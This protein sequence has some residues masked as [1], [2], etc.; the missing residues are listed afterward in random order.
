MRARA[1][2]V[3]LAGLAGCA[4]P[5]TRGTGPLSYRFPEAFTASQVVEVE[6]GGTRLQFLASVRRDGPDCRVTLFD[7][8]FSVPLVEARLEGGKASEELLAPGPRPGDG[9]RLVQLLAEV[10]GRA[11]PEREGEAEATT[12]IGAVHLAGLPPP[13][14]ACRLPAQ[15]QLLPRPGLVVRVRT[16]EGGGGGGGTALMGATWPPG[17]VAFGGERRPCVATVRGPWSRTSS[18]MEGIRSVV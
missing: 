16:V 8:V 10:F 14:Q 9:R 12:I 6:Q 7:P 5:S 3:L 4:T 17:S 13:E 15:I 11:Y 1:L 2:L 18:E